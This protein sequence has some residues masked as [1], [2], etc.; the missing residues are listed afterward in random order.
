MIKDT[1]LPH[2]QIPI[3][4]MLTVLVKSVTPL[5]ILVL[6]LVEKTNVPLVTLVDTYY[7][8]SVEKNAQVDIGKMPLI[9]NVLFVMLLVPLVLLL[10]KPIVTLV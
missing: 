4:P 2:V 8:E 7:K 9:T 3:T 10:V 6:P 5:V 1:V